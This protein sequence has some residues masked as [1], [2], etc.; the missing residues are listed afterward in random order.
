MELIDT[1]CHLYLPAFA[2]DIDEVILKAQRA[3]VSRFYLPAIDIGSE[4]ALLDLEKGYP[5]ICFAMQG[6][7]PCSV[8]S[9]VEDDW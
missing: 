6:L 7:H 3:G 9:D 5:D 2:E 1:H 4:K 8:K